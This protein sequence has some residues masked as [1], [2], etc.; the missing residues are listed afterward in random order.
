M[1]DPSV[2][3]W[4][5]LGTHDVADIV[6]DAVNNYQK[7]GTVRRDVQ[8]NPL[9]SNYVLQ[10]TWGGGSLKVGT[11]Q[12]LQGSMYAAISTASED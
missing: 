11:V 4:V 9:G 8:Y 12:P 5:V 7:W 10:V 3:S 6:N 1:A 2:S